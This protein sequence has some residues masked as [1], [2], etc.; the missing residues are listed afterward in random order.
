MRRFIVGLLFTAASL[1]L[2]FRVIDW[3]TTLAVL[4]AADW[5]FIALAV[6][7]LIVSL[8]AKTV[9]WRL[10][11]PSD[12]QVTTPRLYR[13]LH[14]SFLLNNVLPA[15]LGDVARITMTT[16]QPGVRFGHV[17]SSM[18]TERATDGLTLVA[19]FVLVSPFLPVPN[20]YLPWLHGAWA[21]L[22]SLSAI[23]VVAIALRRRL[24]RV[25]ARLTVGRQFPGSQ[26]LRDEAA[27]FH[28]GLA[29]LASRDHVFSIWGWSWA[30]W[31]GAFA[32][33]YLLMRALG[34]QAPMAVAV[35]LTCTTNL[36]MLLPSSPGY[37]GVFHAAATL[38]L[39]PF[40]VGSAQ[41]FGF[42]ILAHLV[43]VLPVSILGA[44]FLLW[45]RESLN[46]R[47]ATVRTHQV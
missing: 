36:A 43:N 34:I 5:K 47:R 11:L 39:I 3:S 24:G 37:V 19:C 22:A 46:L 29:R 23:V 7:C 8:V 41:A 45:G 13:I 21:G 38:S 4:R 10:L 33:N 40:G 26:R 31:L 16:K 15:R 17:L 9:R 2:L 44:A 35:L 1:A 6:S 32:I 27:S 28:E 12:S 25:F 20:D 14:I 18:L 42:A 30:A